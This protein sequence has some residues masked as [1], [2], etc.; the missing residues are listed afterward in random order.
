VAGRFVV[1]LGGDAVPL[2]Q[3]WLRELVGPVAR[4]EAAACYGRQVPRPDADAA[5]R[6]RMAYN[7]GPK[8]FRKHRDAALSTKNR[9]FFSSVNCCID[10]RA[11]DEPLFDESF[12]VDE[13]A[14]LSRRIID[15]GLGI[16]YCADAAVR[17]S[18]NYGP[19]EM[20]RRSFDNAVVYKRLGIFAN[21]DPS[22]TR[23]AL[24]YLRQGLAEAR[25]A[26][27]GAQGR[28]LAL[29]VCS[30]VGWRL[31]MAH[32]WLPVPLRRALSRF[33]TT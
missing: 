20:L 11:V 9:Y 31:G 1:F 27:L 23:D 32:Q 30:G 16:M 15:A 5:N 13:D 3:H 22:L 6:C 4:G 17:H 33:Q 26:G 8:S 25:R 18:H 28:F 2:E 29:F 14:T 19:G 24:R 12:P 21:G 10:R 7:Y